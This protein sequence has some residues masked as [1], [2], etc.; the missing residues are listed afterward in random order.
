MPDKGN[1]LIRRGR[2]N[3]LRGSAVEGIRRAWLD[4]ALSR[5]RRYSSSGCERQRIAVGDQAC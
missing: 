1:N 2:S 4:R 3:F 5:W